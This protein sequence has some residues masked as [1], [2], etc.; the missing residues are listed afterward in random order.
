M[1]PSG[2]TANRPANRA[3]DDL[4]D[5]AQLLASLFERQREQGHQQRLIGAIVRIGLEQGDEDS[6]PIRGKLLQGDNI[7]LTGGGLGEQDGR[8]RRGVDDEL[9]VAR[10]Q[11]GE[12]QV[13]QR[14][15]LVFR[16]MVAIGRWTHRHSTGSHS[17]DCT[18]AKT[19][20]GTPTPFLYVLYGVMNSPWVGSGQQGVAS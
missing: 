16:L 4:P 11:T 18:R 1:Q 12:G 7:G 20:R 10:E 9:L 13:Q 14:S 5:L 8:S 3:H 17:G 19:Q 6:H 15:W 2:E